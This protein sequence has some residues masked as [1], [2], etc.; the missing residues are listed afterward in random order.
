MHYTLALAFAA[1]ALA[2]PLSHEAS[3]AASSSMRATP[4]SMKA[5]PSSTTASLSSTTASPSSGIAQAPP[6]PSGTPVSGPGSVACADATK[7]P[8][9]EIPL[10]GV[11]KTQTC[12]QPKHPGQES[13]RPDLTGTFYQYDP[14]TGV[15]SNSSVTTAPDQSN[16]TCGFLMDPGLLIQ[17]L[18]APGG[19]CDQVKP[20]LSIL[21]PTK[22]V[23]KI[24]DV[25]QSFTNLTDLITGINNTAFI[26]VSLSAMQVDEVSKY[27]ENPG[28]S[29]AANASD[30]GLLTR[31]GAVYDLMEKTSNSSLV[32][33]RQIDQA[34]ATNFPGSTTNLTA[35]YNGFLQFAAHA[36]NSTKS[37]TE[38]PPPGWCSCSSPVSHTLGSTS[39]PV[40][41]S[42]PTSSSPA[43]LSSATHIPVGPSGSHSPQSTHLGT[44]THHA[45]TGTSSPTSI[46][47]KGLPESS[48]HVSI[49]AHSSKTPA[50]STASHKSSS[51]TAHTSETPATSSTHVVPPP[52][53][54]SGHAA[55]P[56]STT[57]PIGFPSPFTAQVV[58]QDTRDLTRNIDSRP[59][60]T[61]QVVFQSPRGSYLTPTTSRVSATHLTSEVDRR[62]Y[63]SKAVGFHQRQAASIG[64]IESSRIDPSS[65][66]AQHL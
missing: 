32:L 7:W 5:T 14:S 10:L 65:V 37:N 19:P 49:D 39:A 46:S 59:S 66:F 54:T 41:K 52:A 25:K 20:K 22:D 60:F 56:K 23:A 30:P 42:T 45:S 47:T 64:F 58:F 27:A 6:N 2:A 8:N 9:G 53:S 38:V 1:S 36:A 43:H 40:H 17:V 34:L 63:P 26:E 13:I 12:L 51:K 31:V 44:S 29:Y 16:A 50:T 57:S 48:A 21:D 4:S 3:K 28:F 24:T 62:R 18:E 35:T 11:N 33:A 15:V 61:S 55:P